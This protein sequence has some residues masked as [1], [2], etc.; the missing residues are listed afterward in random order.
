MWSA[1]ERG[2]PGNLAVLPN[3]T[4]TVKWIKLKSINYFGALC[5][6]TK[7]VVYLNT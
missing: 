5:W 4:K 1:T 2:V 3:P 6:K 7:C